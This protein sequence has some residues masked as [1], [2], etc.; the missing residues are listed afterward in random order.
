MISRETRAL[1]WVGST[2]LAGLQ[3]TRPSHDGNEDE[4]VD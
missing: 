2:V 4:E 3:A 1:D